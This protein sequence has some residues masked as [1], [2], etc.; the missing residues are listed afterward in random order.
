MD[1]ELNVEPPAKATNDT[2]SIERNVIEQETAATEEV[3]PTSDTTKEHFKQVIYM[4][5]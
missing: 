2:K 1:F 3:I 4:D 5:S